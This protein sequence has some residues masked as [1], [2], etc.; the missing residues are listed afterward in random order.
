MIKSDF[1]SVFGAE[2]ITAFQ[3]QFHLGVA[4]AEL[5]AENLEEEV[6]GFLGAVVADPSPS[7]ADRRMTTTMREASSLLQIQ[8]IDHVIF[9]G[10]QGMPPFYSF[11]D[12]G[13]L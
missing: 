9:G 5:G 3:R 2:A 7:T 1:A 11:R 6:E 10:G 8:L 12:S 13:L 4:R